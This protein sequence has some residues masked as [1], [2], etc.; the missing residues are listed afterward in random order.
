MSM[1]AALSAVT[2]S[3]SVISDKSF[4]STV[5]YLLGRIMS[6]AP[7]VNSAVSVIHATPHVVPEWFHLLLWY[8]LTQPTRS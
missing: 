1:L 7:S 2:V 6:H 3:V 4:F 5:K 8:P